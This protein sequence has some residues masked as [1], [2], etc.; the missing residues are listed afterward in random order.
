[1]AIRTWALAIMA[2]A[3][4]AAGALAQG[5]AP[6][7]KQAAIVNGEPITIDDL[8]AILKA[9][10]IE[11]MKLSSADY[12]AMRLEALNCLVDELIMHQF[13]VK[14]APLV[15]S[16]QVDKKLQELRDS[17]K[18]QGQALDEYCRA[19]GQSMNQVRN[20]IV[21][22]LQWTAYLDS[23]LDEATLRKY[24]ED[25]RDF[26]DRV[27]VRVSHILVRVR[28]EMKPSEREGLSNW[29]LGL[30]QDIVSGKLD[31]ADAA[32]RY[33]QAISAAKGG[34]EGFIARKGTVEESFARAAFALKP[35]EIST[36][37][38]TQSG[39]HLIRVTERKAGTPSDFK[40]MEPKVRMLAGEEFLAAIL[41]QQRQLAQVK[42]TLPAAN[43]QGKYPN[44]Q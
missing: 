34:D 10:P 38:P 21:S 39:L 28:P 25:N 7:A 2:T 8:D 4:L 6:T 43:T 24:Y 31:F 22:A 36:V 23:R 12:R 15:P 18:S 40:T 19:N 30:R 27:S 44:T 9:R 20:S 3:L 26:F 41:A 17:L 5:Q 33:S 1:M 42:I 16:A 11:G 14:N 35:N 32:R 37:V 13:L 29:L